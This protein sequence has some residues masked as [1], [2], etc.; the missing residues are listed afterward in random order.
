MTDTQ[1][2]ADQQ[3]A[4]VASDDLGPMT[5][6]EAVDS[7]TNL[8]DGVD[9]EPAKVSDPKPKTEEDEPDA[10]DEP[11]PLGPD[12]DEEDVENDDVDAKS[13][14]SQESAGKFVSPTAKYKLAD[15]TVISVGDLARNNLFQRDYSQKTEALSREREEFTQK[16][17]E[18]DQLSR[19][20]SEER[21]FLMWFAENHVPQLPPP[22]TDPNDI[23]AE[24]EYQRKVREYQNFANAYQQFKIGA[25]KE[26]ERKTGQ[27]TAEFSKKAGEQV[28]Q[29]FSKLKIDPQKQPQKAEAFFKAVEAGA[30]EFYGLDANTIATMAKQDHR[31]ILVLRDAI[32]A[33]QNKKAAPQV[34][35]SLRNVPKI[36]HQPT[37][38]V[39]PNA[40]QDQTRIATKEKLQRSGSLED[41][42]RAIE[43]L[44][45]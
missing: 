13:D 12:D 5:E 27:T 16:A 34:E 2:S 32:R 39:A 31:A 30:Q 15:G 36:R 40:R 33:R 22:P 37:A 10:S 11:D 43:A 19:T 29:L 41:G 44:L 18:V 24:I 23:V 9:P 4:P 8:L 42:A 14:A 25:D 28:A 3:N 7:L 38:R 26:A 45:Q 1:A 21:Q 17:Q 20:L 35:A 6:A